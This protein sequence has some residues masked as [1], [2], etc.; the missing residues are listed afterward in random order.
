MFI[1]QGFCTPPEYSNEEGMEGSEFVDIEAGG[2]DEG[3][4]SKNVNDKIDQDNLDPGGDDGG[5]EGDKEKR[6]KAEEEK[7][8]NAFEV[9]EEFEGRMEDLEDQERDK[10]SCER[11]ICLF[12]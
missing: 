11:Y 9:D 8:D 10:E 2:F 3:E 5:K 1:H 7:G 12:E 4:G 6:E